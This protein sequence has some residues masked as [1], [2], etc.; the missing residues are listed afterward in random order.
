MG[1]LPVKSKYWS[2]VEGRR[3]VQAWRR[4]GETVTA[5][6][7]RHGL[8]A[9]RVEYWRGRLAGAGDARPRPERVAF[10]PAT[11]V[12]ADEL[13]AVIRA[14]NGVTIELAHATPSQIAAVAAAVAGASS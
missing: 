3:V 10:V 11:V 1:N 7:R 4:S 9:K 5:F 14:P 2:E 8:R 13:V 6:A 12:A